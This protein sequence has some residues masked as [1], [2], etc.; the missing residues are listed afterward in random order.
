[1]LIVVIVSV[2]A[3]VLFLLF[4]GKRRK[5]ED[6][7]PVPAGDGMLF[8]YYEKVMGT[9]EDGNSVEMVLSRKTEG[10]LRLDVYEKEYGNGVPETVRSYRVPE[11]AYDAVCRA[12]DASGM[13]RWEKGKDFCPLDGIVYVCKSPVYAGGFHAGSEVMPEGGERAF[14]AIRGVLSAYRKDEN[15]IT[16]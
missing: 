13:L 16:E 12:V 10:E 2:S 9:P 4:R 3:A 7:V 5:G 8:D 14:S 11:E 6:P 15:R 1:M